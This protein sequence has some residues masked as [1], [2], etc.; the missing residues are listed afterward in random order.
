MYAPMV[1]RKALQLLAGVVWT[2]VGLALCAMAVYWLAITPGNRIV[3]LIAGIIVGILV[4]YF[5][6]MRLV[7]KNKDRIYLQAPGKNKACLFAFQSWSSYIIIVVM[8][9]L[10][11]F[12]RHLAI[13]R[14]YLVPIYL[15]VGIGLFLASLHY[16]SAA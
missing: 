1:N 2:A 6:F 13:S 11:Y 14:L 12:L 10:G 15:A 7:Q 9:T 8:I 16:Y 5:G 3:P 4:Y